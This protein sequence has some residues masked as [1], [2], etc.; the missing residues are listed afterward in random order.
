M[1][2]KRT[3]VKCNKDFMVIDQEIKIYQE[4]DYPLP[5]ECPSCRQKARM[6]RRNERELYAYKCDNCSKDIVVAFN[7]EGDQ[8]VY[9][10]K[11]YQDYM[12]NNDCILGYSEGYKKTQE[13]NE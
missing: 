6:A 13:G 2:K 5:T 7:P 1:A 10:K 12:E 8:D 11:C 3:C 9:C 4:K